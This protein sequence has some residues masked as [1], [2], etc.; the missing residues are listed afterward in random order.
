MEMKTKLYLLVAISAMIHL[1]S[2]VRSSV[3]RADC[4][5]SFDQQSSGILQFP[6]LPM[7]Y[8][9]YQSCVWNIRMQK[10]HKIA[11]SITGLELGKNDV[12]VISDYSSGES[13]SQQLQSRTFNTLEP[14]MVQFSMSDVM[15]VEMIFKQISNISFSA[16]F[17][18]ASCSATLTD[19]AGLI[20][21]P[22]FV[23][24]SSS[25][26]MCTWTIK[27]PTQK[28]I[29]L[30]TVQFFL[31]EGSC[32]F[33]NLYIK[34]GGSPDDHV[35][36]EFCEENPPLGNLIS[37]SN[38]LRVEYEKRP[39]FM[40]GY[41]L[42]RQK[43]KLRYEF[44]DPCGSMVTGMFGSLTVPSVDLSKRSQCNWDIQ[45][46]TS[47]H[48][49][50]RF[51]KYTTA[52]RG[53]GVA[54]SMKIYDGAVNNN[55][56]NNSNN[57]SMLI[58]SSADSRFPPTELLTRTNQLRIEIS[59]SPETT[60]ASRISFNAVYQATSNIIDA[61]DECI[62]IGS[63][64]FFK[65]SN[66]H[67]IDCDW[68]CDGEL[69]CEDGIDEMLCENE[70]TGLDVT[71]I[72]GRK[73][74]HEIGSVILVFAVAGS[75]ILACMFVVSLDRIFCE[76]D[77]SVLRN[78]TQHGSHMQSFVTY[79]L[80]SLPPYSVTDPA[81]SSCSPAYQTERVE[82]ALFKCIKESTEQ[83]IAFTNENRVNS[84]AETT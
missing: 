1:T 22:L 10:N 39:A 19:S 8:Y 46:P 26:Q 45:V 55:N 70:M 84:H 50:L 83:E 5:F 60:G 16:A 29:K 56:S 13:Y 47:Y 28:I 54:Q 33:E 21:V 37:S 62:N 36:G 74:I 78:K 71:P 43:V 25:T 79:Q 66:G 38:T 53:Y 30:S 81:A 2:A 76:H 64:L 48:V 82:N 63:R 12:L 40:Q 23:H 65:C 67:Y 17:E 49:S 15:R 18:D 44:V 35:I 4:N 72:L 42:D 51:L 9:P 32:I 80:P 27:A 69:D 11:L 59:P 31:Q 7:D 6:N 3:A 68:K 52:K 24:L 58:W 77:Y 57:S 20:E 61:A 14:N 75:A 73:S 34:D 41:Q